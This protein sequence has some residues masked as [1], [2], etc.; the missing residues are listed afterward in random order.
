[1]CKETKHLINYKLHTDPI[2][3]SITLSGFGYIHSCSKSV[4]VIICSN[5]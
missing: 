3:A 2:I 1:M 5:V 4:S